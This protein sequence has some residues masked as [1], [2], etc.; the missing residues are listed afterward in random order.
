MTQAQVIRALQNG[1]MN[2]HQL[3]DATGMSK[4]TVLS[5]CKKL[6]YQGKLTTEQVKVGRFW[7][8]K[9]T[10]SEDMIENRPK[11]DDEETRCKLNPFDIRNAKGI[12]TPTEYRVMAAQARRLYGGNPNFTANK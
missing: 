4:Q 9:Y 12:F 1:P 2:S 10:L 7:L 6:R 3:A 8:A 11:K 5:T